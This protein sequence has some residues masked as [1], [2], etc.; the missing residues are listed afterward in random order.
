MRVLARE[1]WCFVLG[2]WWELELKKRIK[3]WNWSLMGGLPS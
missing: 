1:R 2:L 3:R